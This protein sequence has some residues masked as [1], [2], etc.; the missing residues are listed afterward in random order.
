MDKGTSVI[1]RLKNKSKETGKS[2]QLYLQLFCQEE[3]LRRVSMSKYV[4]N[5]V[6]KG[7]L[8][9]YTLTNFESRPTIDV[10]FLIKQLPSSV[11]Q[12]RQI[13]NEILAIDTG[14]DFIVFETKGYEE[15]S[16][17]RKYKGISFQLI[18]QIRNTRTPFNVDFGVGDIIVPKAEKR[19]IPV[20]LPD[21]SIPE[22]STYSLESTI[23]E[24]FDAMLQRLELTSRM[25]DYYDICFIANT[26]NFD[27]RKLQEAIVETLQNRGTDW[28]RDSFGE[29]MSY[30]QNSAMLVKWR[31]FLKR[32][33]LPEQDF[34]EVLGIM[35]KFL[36]GIWTAIVD[37]KEFFGEWDCSMA[38]WV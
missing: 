16:P 29:L 27:G 25:K 13:V 7:G 23:A 20:Q 38:E 31:Q 10:D 1:A 22:V 19:K 30:S 12:V 37:E 18:G 35:Q 26:F 5:L 24:K 8:F 3:F 17:Q 21:F 4:E 15:I 14:N 11:D 9:I 32:T 28:N 34:A 6:L 36:G 2:F 33:R